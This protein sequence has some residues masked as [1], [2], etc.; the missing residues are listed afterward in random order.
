MKNNRGNTSFSGEKEN[1]EMKKDQNSR[2]HWHEVHGKAKLR[3]I[4]DYYKFPL[5]LAGILLYV[6]IWS[7]WRN[8]VKQDYGLYVGLVNVVPSEELTAELGNDF[9]L[10]E[11]SDPNSEPDQPVHILLYQGLF[12]TTD[13][14]SEYHQYT[15]ASRMKLLGAMN[16]N[17]LDLVLMDREAFDAFSQNGYLTDLSLLFSDPENSEESEDLT[18]MLVQNVF[19]EED[20]STDV[21]L[22]NTDQYHAVTREGMYGLDLSRS[23]PLFRE[24][25]LSGTVYLGI[26]ENSP[27]KKEAVQYVQLLTS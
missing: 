6:I 8:A 22:G 9:Y 12:L 21:M 14:N 7:I 4:F 23:S 1:T 13:P 5:V 17:R 15:Y 10:Q 27:R 16:A 18:D 24:A 11:S 2:S 25:D 20:N 26:V 3:Y 19:I